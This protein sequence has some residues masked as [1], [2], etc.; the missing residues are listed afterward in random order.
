MSD[1]LQGFCILSQYQYNT[2]EKMINKREKMLHSSTCGSWSL[3][4]QC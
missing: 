2:C 3:A 1:G 4:V